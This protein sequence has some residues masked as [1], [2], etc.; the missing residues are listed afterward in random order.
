MI[1]FTA[2]LLIFI[3][4]KIARVHKKEESMTLLFI[5]QYMLVLVSM[6]FI[7]TTAFTTYS[8]YTV[9]L[10]SLLFFI[11]SALFVTLIQLGIFVDGKPLFG[12]SRLYRYLPVLTRSSM[13][14]SLVLVYV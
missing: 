5:I 4:L 13:L 10:V 14:L 6:I 9:I 12:L 2:L 7:F 11:I 3:Y 1:L 8:W